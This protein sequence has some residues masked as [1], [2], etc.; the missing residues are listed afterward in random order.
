MTL[1][2]PRF[3][4][5]PFQ[6]SDWPFF[7]QIRQDKSVM[8]YMAEIASE[9]QIRTLFEDRLNDPNAFVIRN[10]QGQA[11]GD[12]GLRP[13]PH[14]LQEADV[15]Y[16]I[17]PEA[18]GQGVASEVLAVLCDFAFRERDIHALNAWVLSDNLGS[19][20]VLEKSGFTRVQVLEQA[21]LLRGKYYDDW[22]YR[23]EKH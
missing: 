14:L 17:L 19:V 5:T 12:V 15:G 3:T 6:A 1:Q 18:Q 20:R 2:T 16:S 10:E 4:L 9:S 21:Y 23:R 8:R 13:S 7:L 22:I 11:I